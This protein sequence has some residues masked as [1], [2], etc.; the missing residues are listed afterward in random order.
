MEQIGIKLKDVDLYYS[1][2]AF[3]E[4]SLKAAVL[5]C[6]K[7]RKKDLQD[8]HALKHV[9]VEIKAGERVALLG[10]NGAGRTTT[11]RAVLSTC[12]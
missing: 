10:R 5:S 4:R 2:M 1:S 11:L 8:I 9:S 6:W 12:M 3:K 7:R